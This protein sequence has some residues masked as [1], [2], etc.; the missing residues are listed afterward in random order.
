MADSP[1]TAG[2]EPDKP[3]IDDVNRD[4]EDELTAPERFPP[5]EEAGLLGESNDKKSEANTLFASAKY[6]NAIAKY[7]EAASAC[8]HYLYY[9][10]AVL[11]SNIAACHLKLEQWKEAIK[12][13]TDSINGLDRLEK[14]EARQKENEGKQ[15]EANAEEEEVEE[16]IVSSGAQKSAPA[17]KKET[18]VEV[19]KQKR[20]N[21]ILR[22]RA[23][24]LMRRARARSELGG[25]SNLSSAEED[26]KTLSTMTNLSA[27]DRKIVQTQLIILPSRTKAAQEKE[28]SE[29]WGKLKD[30]GNGILKPFGLSTDNFNMVKDEKTGGYSM[31]FSQNGASQ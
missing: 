7:E 6:E 10:L 12:A 24:A 22:I 15:K 20:H 23:K 28:M 3:T 27:A 26:Y 11:K 5:E 30:L 18:A 19:A 17:T 13:A 9:E 1:E 21:D 29:M 2:K 14:A 16:E 8:P 25:W 31:N 4:A